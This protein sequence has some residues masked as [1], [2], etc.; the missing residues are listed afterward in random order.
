MQRQPSTS[1]QSETN[2]RQV[3]LTD[4]DKKENIEEGINEPTKENK[5]NVKQHGLINDSDKMVLIF[6]FIFT[7]NNA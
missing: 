1:N 4:N 5:K 6:L 3:E 7:D 2:D